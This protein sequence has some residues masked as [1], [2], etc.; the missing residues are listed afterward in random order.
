M[1]GAAHSMANPLTA[2]FGTV[3]GQAVGLALPHIVRFNAY[4]P[5]VLSLYHDLAL[6][7]GIAAS[8]DNMNTAL[9]KFVCRLEAVLEQVGLATRLSELGVK[10]TDVSLLAQEAGKQ[11][12]ATFNPRPVTIQDFERLYTGAL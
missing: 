5:A 9:E 2:H 11:W 6:Y 10:A 7:A 1:L 8:E 12:T 3:H 4:E